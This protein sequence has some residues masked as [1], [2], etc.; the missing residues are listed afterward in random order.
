ME[1]M[2]SKFNLIRMYGMQIGRKETSQVFI[3]RKS[4]ISQDTEIEMHMACEH[5][6]KSDWGL[7]KENTGEPKKELNTL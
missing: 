3:V 4:I 6:I 7:R 5:H 2:R 1:T